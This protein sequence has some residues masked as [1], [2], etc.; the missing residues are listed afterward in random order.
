MR[1]WV[2]YADSKF[3]SDSKYSAPFHSRS[4]N[5]NAV[6][7]AKYLYNKSINLIKQYKNGKTKSLTFE[8]CKHAKIKNDT[9]SKIYLDDYY[10]G[11]IAK[12]G[13]NKGK[14]VTTN[15]K[16]KNLL[17]ELNK[18][19][20][21]GLQSYALLGLALH[22]VQDYFAHLTKIDVYKSNKKYF[23]GT[24]TSFSNNILKNTKKFEDNTSVIPWRYNNS[25]R[26]TYVI[27]DLYQK[28]KTIKRIDVKYSNNKNDSYLYFAG[29]RSNFYTVKSK[30][31]Y[32]TITY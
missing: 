18:L 21:R 29:G 30:E 20:N 10:L 1:N 26:V 23:S 4:S 3:S 14:K 5:P 24:T 7:I 12:S 27:Y 13:S 11:F 2:T 17:Y 15:E 9:N 22:V 8:Y 32:L 19:S 31:Y 16:A 25:K 6:N 28:Q